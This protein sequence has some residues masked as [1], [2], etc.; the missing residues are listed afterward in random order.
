MTDAPLSEIPIPLPVKDVSSTLSS[1]PESL[2]AQMIVALVT[3]ISLIILG[4]GSLIVIV[5]CRSE[6]AIVTAMVAVPS[7]IAGGLI[8][9]LAAPSG[10]GS[11]IAAARKTQLTP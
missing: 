1:G 7:V 11:V 10:I 6:A 9:S 4:V 3:I 5:I 8:N 2:S